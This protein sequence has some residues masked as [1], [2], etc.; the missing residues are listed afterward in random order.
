MKLNKPDGKYKNIPAGATNCWYEPKYK[1][2]KGGEHVI[3]G[4]TPLFYCAECSTYWVI[5]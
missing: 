3:T 2:N 4:S 5:K 1:C